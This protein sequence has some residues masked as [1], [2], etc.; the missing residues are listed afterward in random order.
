V[1]GSITLLSGKIQGAIDA[2]SAIMPG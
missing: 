2:V 1:V